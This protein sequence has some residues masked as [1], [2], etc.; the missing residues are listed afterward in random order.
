[1]LL[2]K[3]VRIK[4]S[5]YRVVIIIQPMEICVMISN[6]FDFYNVLVV[7]INTMKTMTFINNNDVLF[8]MYEK[9]FLSP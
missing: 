4:K 5:K 1:M 3:E 9:H 7:F 8:L 2:K 6:R